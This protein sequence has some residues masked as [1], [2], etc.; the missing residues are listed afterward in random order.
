MPGSPEWVVELCDLHSERPQLRDLL[1]AGSGS[2]CRDLPRSVV[3]INVTTG[4]KGRGR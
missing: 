4:L 3:M 1:P 2:P